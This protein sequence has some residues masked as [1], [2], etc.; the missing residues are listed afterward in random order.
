M[1]CVIKTNFSTVK[2]QLI[3]IICFPKDRRIKFYVDSAK[4]LGVLAFLAI[5][6]YCLLMI[7][8]VKVAPAN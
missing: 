2:G 5:L 4:F 1:V 7:K 8:L 3:R 6:S